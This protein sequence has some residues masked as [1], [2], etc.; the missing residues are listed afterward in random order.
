MS[1]DPTYGVAG[2]LG[3]TRQFLHARR[4][5]FTHPLTGAEIDLESALP[6]DLAEALTLARA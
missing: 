2:D 3:L 6:G 1:G 5:R 4:I